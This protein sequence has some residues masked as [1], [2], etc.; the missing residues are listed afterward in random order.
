MKFTVDNQGNLLLLTNFESELKIT[1]FQRIKK[2]LAR[3]KPIHKMGN[4]P[5][6]MMKD[7]LGL[8]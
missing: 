6:M 3:K 7:Y 5:K 1:F 8:K 2:K 4:Q